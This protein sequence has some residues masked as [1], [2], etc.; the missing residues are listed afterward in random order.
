MFN[1]AGPAARVRPVKEKALPRGAKLGARSERTQEELIASFTAWKDDVDPKD[2]ETLESFGITMDVLEEAFTAARRNNPTFG[3]E[4]QARSGERL[5][6]EH[7][8]GD[9]FKEFVQ[10]YIDTLKDLATSKEDPGLKYK[11]MF[12]PNEDMEY[13]LFDDEE[14]RLAALRREHQR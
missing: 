14:E 8:P 4:D 9:H 6:M 13:A 5:R 1:K 3:V 2:I 11:A 7:G 10:D 12:L